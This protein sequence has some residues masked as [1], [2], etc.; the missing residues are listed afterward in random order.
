MAF[1]ETE[2][3]EFRLPFQIPL[4]GEIVLKI[5][6]WAQGATDGGGTIE[7]GIGTTGGNGEVLAALSH[8][9][10]KDKSIGSSIAATTGIV[11]LDVDTT[12]GPTDGWTFLLVRKS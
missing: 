10:V 6:T 7:T 4:L 5:Y 9:N 1:V 8:G 3:G 2:I 12:G 11:T